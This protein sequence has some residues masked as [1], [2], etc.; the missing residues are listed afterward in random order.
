MKNEA[1]WNPRR[2]PKVDRIVLIC[3]PEDSGRSAAL[4]SG[5]FDMIDAPG[6]DIIDR[7]K[8]SL[9]STELRRTSA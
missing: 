9:L 5:T 1:Y 2:M 8:Q 3:A 6:P 7:L 4:L